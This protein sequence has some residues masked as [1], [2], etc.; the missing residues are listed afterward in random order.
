[1]KR[2]MYVKT[3]ACLLAA[4]L[5]LSCPFPS[6][7]DNSPGQAAA[8]AAYRRETAVR[9]PSPIP[10]GDLGSQRAVQQ[11]NFISDTFRAGL[12]SFIYR[13]AAA[14][15]EDNV[16]NRSYSP[17]SL[18]YALS[19]AAQGAGQSTRSQL[20]TLLAAPGQDPGQIA[21]ECGRLYR[22][23]YRDNEVC[24]IHPANSLWIK[25]GS[26]TAGAYRRTAEQQLY[27]D[28][29][30]INLLD[31]GAAG[32]MSQ[33]ISGQTRQTIFP[34]LAVT[35][36]EG[37]RI[38]STLCFSGQWTYDFD[39]TKNTAGPF[40]LAD[41]RE[42][43]CEY[44]TESRNCSYYRGQGFLRAAL[45]LKE[46]CTMLFILP[47]KGVTPQSLLLSDTAVDG[48]FGPVVESYGRTAWKVPKFQSRTSLDLKPMLE[49][50]G[51]TDAFLPDKAD[52]SGITGDSLYLGGVIQETQI[53][54]DE[55]GVGASAYAAIPELGST[56]LPDIQADMTLDRPFLYAVVGPQGVPLLIGICADPNA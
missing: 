15:M 39:R 54:L 28:I 18:Y 25:D 22:V 10:Y 12:R 36:D 47:D 3:R 26:P 35:K 52:F 19:L 33:W 45:P 41:G 21:D 53:R 44:M 20:Y 5:T 50:M 48:M 11:N 49:G 23:Q 37:M 17:V 34:E 24:T 32:V 51:I 14:V 6:Y 55:N 9:N 16:G 7:A 1:M 40:Y 38:I 42:T 13:T 56:P 46:N 31:E 30:R 29:F 2:E 8:D 27:S 43:T 4:A